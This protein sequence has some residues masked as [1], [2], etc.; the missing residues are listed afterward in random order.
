MTLTPALRCII[1]KTMQIKTQIIAL[2]L[3]TGLLFTACKKNSADDDDDKECELTVAAIAGKYKLVAAKLLQGSNEIDV[4][5]DI[6]E[7]CELDD[8]NELKADKT[9]IYTDA[10]VSCVP[11]NSESGTWDVSGRSLR[12]NSGF[13]NIESFNCTYLVITYR[14]EDSNLIKETYQRQ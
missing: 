3:V 10:G 2:L 8:I 4:L 1:K 11:N 13:S 12:L 9:F 6:Y 5:R 14:D 7:P